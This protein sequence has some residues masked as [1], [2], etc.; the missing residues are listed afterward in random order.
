M[1]ERSGRADLLHNSY[2][3]ASSSSGGTS[4]AL[5]RN[6]IRPAPVAFPARFLKNSVAVS[7]TPTFSATATAIHWFSE[8]P[9]SLGGRW[10]AF[11]ID[12]GSFNGISS[13]AHPLTFFSRS[14]GRRIGVANRSPAAAKSE[15][16]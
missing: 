7:T 1:D 3:T 5:R 13:L 6:F 8:T 15:T 2:L 14:T 10:A 16:L 12:R 4:G 9:S 11:L